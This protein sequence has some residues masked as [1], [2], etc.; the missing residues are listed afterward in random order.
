MAQFVKI[1]AL[2]QTFDCTK[3]KYLVE[4]VKDNEVHFSKKLVIADSFELALNLDIIAYYTVEKTYI[5]DLLAYLKQEK[6]KI[7]TTRDSCFATHKVVFN[8]KLSEEELNAPTEYGAIRLK[9]NTSWRE[10]FGDDRI[11]VRKETIEKLEKLMSGNSN[12]II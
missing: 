9:N 4:Y 3:E 7:E 8:E 10:D 11:L 1:E 12:S 6:A 5:F 2:R